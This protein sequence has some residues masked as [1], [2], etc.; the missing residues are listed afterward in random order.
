MELDESL[1]YE[2][3]LLENEATSSNF[4]VV[5]RLP[6]DVVFAS[7]RDFVDHPGHM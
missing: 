1:S 3:P 4:L 7:S 5:I 6:E 2:S